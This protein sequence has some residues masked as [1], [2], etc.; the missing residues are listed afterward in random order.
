MS[1]KVLVM[2]LYIY[3]MRLFNI[4]LFIVE[5]VITS[6]YDEYLFINR[7][8]NETL[9]LKISSYIWNF[10]ALRCKAATSCP[11][12]SFNNISFI[13]VEQIRYFGLHFNM[14][15]THK[16]ETPRPT[17][18]LLLQ[19][20]KNAPNF[21]FTIKLL[22]GQ[23]VQTRLSFGSPKEPWNSSHIQP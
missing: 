16:T 11:T 12:V 4:C 8:F 10:C 1:I 19:H 18:Y 5:S 7:L 22:S 21:Q 20:S 3:I 6:L 15:L 17:R 9:E 13:S 14:R 23:F 2:V